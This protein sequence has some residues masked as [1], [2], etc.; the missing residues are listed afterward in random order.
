[1]PV[2]SIEEANADRGT[3][4]FERPMTDHEVLWD[5][6]RRQLAMDIDMKGLS[7]R[8][9]M[10]E[11]FMWMCSGALVVIGAIVVPRWLELT[12]G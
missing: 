6:Y 3:Q 10:V 7:R 4:P 2:Q 12:G 8:V 9:T 11:R 5:I 1:M